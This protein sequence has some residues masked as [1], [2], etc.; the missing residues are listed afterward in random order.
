MYLAL[1]KNIRI[2]QGQWIEVKRRI[3][4]EVPI[5]KGQLFFAVL[6]KEVNKYWTGGAM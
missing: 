2:L 4:A 6:V 5:E 1:H 3:D